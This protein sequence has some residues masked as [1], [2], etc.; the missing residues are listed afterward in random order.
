M[1]RLI[2]RNKIPVSHPTCAS[3]F[4]ATIFK[5]PA[6]LV[7]L[8]APPTK[9]H[10]K[11]I[12][13]VEPIRSIRASTKLRIMAEE[14]SNSAKL[15]IREPAAEAVGIETGDASL[16]GG[17]EG[18]GGEKVSKKAAKK[19]E[20]KAKKDA[21]K[22]QRAAEREAAAGAAKQEPTEDLAKDNYGHDSAPWPAGL[23]GDAV[24]VNLKN[25][26]EEHVGKKVAIRGWI[27]KTRM[28]SAKMY[29]IELR[30][31]GN[32]T[33]QGL[34]SATSNPEEQ[35]ASG[36]H[37]VSRP[38]VKWIGAIAPESF[39][40]VEAT[41]AKP[42]EPVKSC[43][44]SE[45]E[46]HILKCYVIAAAPGMLGM[47]LA[48]ANR[49]VTNFSDE[50]PGQSAVQE[51]KPADKANESNVPA[52]TMLTHLDN[53]VMHKRSP[54]QQAIAVRSLREMACQSKF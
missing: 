10:P 34:V 54:V 14:G 17:A 26:S 36:G 13:T 27:Q 49:A 47:T 18:E 11:K 35:Q 32:W 8:I 53:I 20:A 16:E 41:V 28:Q 25:L 6:H 42:L 12:V 39:V 19:A 40:A 24:E 21:L 37:I 4:V 45:F 44:V 29:F 2:R 23:S 7:P 46:L 52:A 5:P 50:D 9:Q 33:I 1:R 48:A 51:E 31:E 38:M 22:A 15:P 3:C 43:R 30:E